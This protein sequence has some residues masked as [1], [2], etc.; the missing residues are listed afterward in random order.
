MTKATARPNIVFI[1]ADDMG[2]GDLSCYGATRIRTPNMDRLAEEGVR[3]TDMHSSASVCTPSR[4]SVITGR[5]CWRTHLTSGVLWGYGAPLIERERLTVASLLKR[6]GYAT[7]A[8]GK[9]HLGL[10]WKRPGGEPPAFLPADTIRTGSGLDGFD[11]DYAQPATGGP[12]ELGF[13][14]WF[15]IAGSLDMPP[16]CFIENGRTVGVPDCEKPTYYNQQRRG[17][18]VADWRDE[19]VDITF[20]RKAVE[21]MEGHVAVRPDQPFF[22]YLPTASPHRPCDVQPGFVK[23]KS[24]AGDRGDMVMLFDWVVGQ[25]TDTLDRLGIRENTLLIVSS[26]NGARAT[27]ANGEDYGHR[28]NGPWR[29]QKADI[30]D[31]G[32]REPFIASWP[33]RMAKAATCG[34]LLCLSDFMATCAA[35][36]GEPLPADAAEDSFDMLPA[37][38]GDSTSPARDTLVHHSGYGMFSVRHGRWKAVFG[39]GSGGFTEPRSEEPQPGGPEGQL[40]DLDADPAE[41]DNLWQTRPEIVADLRNRLE[42][43]Q[44]GG[45][46][47]T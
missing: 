33:A 12:T 15:G 1:L 28:A 38:L 40:Y 22:L 27:C 7:A 44:N 34:Q 21:F 26:D 39:L 36:V 19:E 3:F 18:A 23:G 20:A 14:S 5:Y 2:Y 41:T 42:A 25:V 17:P 16:Y 6:R 11:L 32:H 9:W 8:V 35:I 24:Q 46:S 47:R 31:G 10:D 13:D 43:I 45:R 37:L 29:G 4:Y 30:W